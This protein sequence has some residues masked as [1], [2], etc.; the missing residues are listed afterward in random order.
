MR[1]TLAIARRELSSFFFSP[2]AYV[3]LALFLLL[4]GFMFLVY[5]LRS[6]G[7]AELRYMFTAIVWALVLVAPAISMR[8]ISDELRSGTIEPLM[9]APV[10]DTAVIVGKWLGAMGFYAAMLLATGVFVGVLCYF[11]DPDF[12][13]IFTGYIGLLLVGGFYLAI[14]TFA[15]VFSRN[16]IIAFLITG[17][18]ILVFTV[19]TW[20]LPEAIPTKFVPVVIYLNV[21]QQFEDFAKGVIDLRPFVFFL[22]GIVLFLTL[23]VKALESR[24]WR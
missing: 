6:G 11:S 17:A 14:G 21:N 16:Q 23:G 5:A 15:S 19:V 8:L 12:G 18:F 24:K 1:S 13:P 22:S 20:F 9:T 4:A 2:V 7:P 3:V 10:S